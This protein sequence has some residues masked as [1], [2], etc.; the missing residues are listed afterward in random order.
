M[1]YL[2]IFEEFN[3]EFPDVFNGTLKRGVKIDK[4]EYIDDPKSRKVRIGDCDEDHYREFLE[5]YSK[6]GIP[7]PTKSVH[8]YFRGEL[9]DKYGNQYNIIPKKDA[10]FGFCKHID[11][12]NG[13]LGNT[14]FGVN[15]IVNKYMNKNIDIFDDYF[16][17]Y[18]EDE[19]KYLEEVTE[20]QKKLIDLGLV[21]V[22]T[23]DELVKM[24]K[25]EGETLQ[26]WTESPCLHKK[27]IDAKEPKEPKPY[28]SEPVLTDDDFKELG[29]D[30]KGR[31]EFYKQYG[32][33][34]NNSNM[35]VGRRRRVALDILKKW[36]PTQ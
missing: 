36:A 20:Y 7:N 21:G 12:G 13:T 14:Y 26:V 2:K 27:I 8:M 33:E 5:N 29:I 23:Y 3:D 30:N 1:K 28:K 24:S 16:T 4:D 32:N 18:Y 31:S 10:V 35:A 9:N 11:S 25:E 15:F 19:K 6:L 22:L 17:D 34:I